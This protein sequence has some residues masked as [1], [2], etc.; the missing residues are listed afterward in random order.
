MAGPDV[1]SASR[2]KSVPVMRVVSSDHPVAL[3]LGS[4]FSGIAG[5]VKPVRRISYERFEGGP[6]YAGEA[7]PDIPSATLGT[8]DGV[9]TI[10]YP[11]RIHLYQGHSAGEVT[12]AV[13][14]AASCGCRVAVFVGACG[15]ID[16]E[17][18]PRLGIVSDHINLTGH[19]PLIGKKHRGD[20]FVPMTNAY[21][22]GLRALALE[23]AKDHGIAVREGVYAE[24]M[25]PSLETEAERR[26]LGLLGAN[27]VGMSLSLEAIMAHALGIRVLAITLATNRAG[28]S[29]VSH[30]SV[31]AETTS[32]DREVRMLVRGVLERLQGMRA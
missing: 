13:R 27:F 6:S 18:S 20:S 32:Y 28:A 9:P 10:V 21:D 15:M 29:N 8:I 16:D 22:A 19:N 2:G 5:L 23:V 25:G 31:R 4:G 24:V 17:A 1:L 12:S 26:A 3:A 7:A 11:R 30:Q 14:H